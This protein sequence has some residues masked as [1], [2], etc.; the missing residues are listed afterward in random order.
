MDWEGL[1]S[2]LQEIKL[3]LE[4]VDEPRVDLIEKCE[5]YISTAI[6][7]EIRDEV[8]K[9]RHHGTYLDMTGSK[10]TNGER[11]IDYLP[12]KLRKILFPDS[13]ESFMD[14]EQS[15][16]IDIDCA[17]GRSSSPVECP[18]I[19]L[20]FAHL[21]LNKNV[22][23]IQEQMRITGKKSPVTCA[24]L[25]G[26]WLLYYSASKPNALKPTKYFQVVAVE[27]EQPLEVKV[28]VKNPQNDPQNLFF[29][30]ISVRDMWIKAIR[31]EVC[32]PDEGAVYDDP[33]NLR[34]DEHLYKTLRFN[35]DIPKMP[36]KPV[37]APPQQPP[38]P[39]D[40]QQ[41]QLQQQ[42]KT[43][44]QLKYQEIK[45]QLASQLKQK[46]PRI[47][48]PERGQGP[49]TSPQRRLGRFI[50]MFRSSTSTSPP[51]PP[52][53]NSNAD[54]TLKKSPGKT[55]KIMKLKR[56]TTIFSPDY[57]IVGS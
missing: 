29:D 47:G 36:P 4:K 50:S 25:K 57:E 15:E 54:V 37:Q 55:A 5:F 51:S 40:Q 18:Y 33:N 9:G 23:I 10:S 28:L 26:S 17:P 2:F 12:G 6:N 42:Q 16:Y 38:P 21:K 41:Q 39:L 3:F 20:P 27:V 7:Q 52:P 56:N 43:E 22:L 24:L 32:N 44:F 49:V 34:M 30:S 19:G 35:Y 45:E 1:S 14:H 8:D 53:G 13:T 48:S 31:E 11:E 46:S